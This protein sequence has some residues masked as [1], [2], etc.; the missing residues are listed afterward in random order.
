MEMSWIDSHEDVMDMEE[1]W[2]QYVLSAVEARHGAAIVSC[3]GAEIRVRRCPFPVTMAE[4]QEILRQ[5]GHV[6]PADSK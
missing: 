6:P 2:L 1:R 4:A 3:W 5:A